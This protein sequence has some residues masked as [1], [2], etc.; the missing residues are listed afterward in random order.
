MPSYAL[1][2]DSPFLGCSLTSFE[3]KTGVQSIGSCTFYNCRSLKEVILANTVSCI[4]SSAFNGCESLASVVMPGV[5]NIASFAFRGCSALKSIELPSVL[6]EIGERSFESCGLTSLTVPNGVTNIGTYAF[7]SLSSLA[8][9]TIPNNVTSL[10]EYVLYGSKGNLVVNCSNISKNAFA[11]ANLTNVTIGE[12]VKTIESN[13]FQNNASLESV[14]VKSKKLTS[15]GSSAFYQCNILAKVTIPDIKSWCGVAFS[16]QG[17]PLWYGANLYVN[18]QLV[19]N[20]VVPNGV[21]EIKSY[22][23]YNC[24][25]LKTVKIPQSLHSIQSSTF[26]DCTNLTNVDMESVEAWCNIAFANATSNPLYYANR[27]TC[28]GVTISNLVIPENI[29]AI[30]PYAFCNCTTLKSL[31]FHCD[32]SEIG[33]YAFNGCGNLTDVYNKRTTPQTITNNQFSTY[34][35]LYVV[36]GSKATFESATNWKSFTITE[37]IDPVLV[38]NIVLDKSLY[39]G[40]E[41]NIISPVATISPA[42]ASYQT[43]AWTSSDP[44]ICNVNASTGRIVCMGAGEITLT[45]K[46]TDGSGV[47]KTAKVRVGEYTKTTDISLNKTTLSLTEGESLTLTATVLPSNATD[48]TVVWSTSD[49]KV[50]TVEN[51]KVTAN[52]PGTVVITAK[53]NDGSNLSATCTISVKRTVWNIADGSLDVYIVEASS[54]CDQIKYTRTFNNTQWQALYV[55]FSMSYDDW[56]DHFE[57]ARVNAFYE[58]ER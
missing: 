12:D 7:G 40:E 27:L 17:N 19:E 21:E 53:T 58:Y 43:L 57:V 36:K 2:T 54:L 15:V 46:A 29:T 18:N 33:T 35:N 38:A 6:T 44:S 32:V 39:L 10:G 13:A 8:T 41:G 22:A 3:A 26:S 9:I 52:G 25:S 14:D 49:S 16:Y 1:N 56:K 28:N 20:L 11:N 47:T 55:P 24:K 5:K 42:N 37:D 51:G 30:Q 48:K 45:V 31:T 4:E 23:F 34:G 50:A